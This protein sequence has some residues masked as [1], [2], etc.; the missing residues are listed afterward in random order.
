MPLKLINHEDVAR[1]V[2]QEYERLAIS[3][4]PQ[5]FAFFEHAA[6]NSVLLPQICYTSTI[7]SEK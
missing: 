5:R 2:L 4:N 7:D 1:I 6:A 3:T